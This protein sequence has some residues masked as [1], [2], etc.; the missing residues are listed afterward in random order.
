ME[1]TSGG[2]PLFIPC[3]Y[4]GEMDVAKDQGGDVSL[5][6]IAQRLQ[7]DRLKGLGRVGIAQE[8]E[9]KCI[10]LR[11]NVLDRHAVEAD[12]LRGFVVEREQV[13]N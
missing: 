4:I 6:Q 7:E 5:T 8:R 10:C 13:L 3:S 2:C 12:A 1:K 11:L 9:A